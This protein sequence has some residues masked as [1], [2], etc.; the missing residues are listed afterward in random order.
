MS[1]SDVVVDIYHLE[2][3]KLIK[4]DLYC[5]K[6]GKL[7]S[8][9]KY[10]RILGLYSKDELCKEALK[11][12]KINIWENKITNYS[13]KALCIDLNFKMKFGYLD[14]A[15]KKGKKLIKKHLDISIED[16]I[17]LAL[18]LR[19]KAI[20]LVYEHIDGITTTP[21][22]SGYKC[23]D[24]LVDLG[25][26]KI[27]SMN[28]LI[29]CDRYLN[30]FIGFPSWQELLNFV[31]LNYFKDQTFDWE[32]NFQYFFNFYKKNP[33]KTPKVY[34]EKFPKLDRSTIYRWIKK[35]KHQST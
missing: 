23:I 22:R 14:N 4:P 29:H 34:L 21:R 33:N 9:D 24:L 13:A 31:K 19:N 18:G 25:L 35:C 32:I 1:L 26:N 6:K 30:R 8:I 28:S 27:L 2:G 5:K 17:V 7:N 20:A 11:L 15:F 10:N 16:L 3:F 12:I